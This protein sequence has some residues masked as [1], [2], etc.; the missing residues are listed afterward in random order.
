MNNNNCEQFTTGM[1]AGVPSESMNPT[2]TITTQHPTHSTTSNTM[3]HPTTP[4]HPTASN[5]IQQH[6][7]PVL[8]L[9]RGDINAA[10]HT[11]APPKSVAPAQLNFPMPTSSIRSCSTNFVSSIHTTFTSNG[12]SDQFP[13][14]SYVGAWNIVERRAL[15]QSPWG[16]HNTGGSTNNSSKQGICPGHISCRCKNARMAFPFLD[17]GPLGVDLGSTAHTNVITP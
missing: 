11:S 5:T 9:N 8:T 6:Q 1:I 10:P 7:M 13:G 3:P 14:S 4:H 15:S 17:A 12:C 16:A 2:A